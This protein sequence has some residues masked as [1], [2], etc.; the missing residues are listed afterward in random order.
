M[1]LSDS[2]PR[3]VTYTYALLLCRLRVTDE[4]HDQDRVENVY[5]FLFSLTQSLL[6]S[7]ECICL[8]MYLL[9]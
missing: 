3:H 6:F 5:R 4:A 2:S 1:S 8:F 7:Y 9:L